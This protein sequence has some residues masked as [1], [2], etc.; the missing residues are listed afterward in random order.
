MTSPGRTVKTHLFSPHRE[1]A[2]R[3]ISH[4]PAWQTAAIIR[5]TYKVTGDSKAAKPVRKS[6]G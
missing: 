3:R 6:T 5:V 1:G 4:N 2:N